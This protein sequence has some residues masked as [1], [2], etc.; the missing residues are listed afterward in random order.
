MNENLYSLI[1]HCCTL[2]IVII[3]DNSSGGKAFL[4]PTKN[5]S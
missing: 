5:H 4:S 2:L 1:S 3:G